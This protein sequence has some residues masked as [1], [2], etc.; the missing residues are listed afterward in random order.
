MTKQ[1]RTR[2]VC[3]FFLAMLPVTKIFLLP[4]LLAENARQDMWISAL[5]NLFLDLFTLW[6]V[7]RA[8]KNCSTDFFGVLENNFGKIGSKFVLFIYVIF[9]MLKAILP[10]NEQKD[11]VESTLYITMPSLFTF[12]PFFLVTF[13]LCLKKLNAIGRVSDVLFLGTL[14]GLILI[15]A[16]AIP[17]ADLQ[18]FLPLGVTGAKSVLT[19]SYKGLNWFGDC[20][21]FLFFIGNFT[22]EKNAE[23]NILLSYLASCLLSVLFLFLFYATFS[24]IAFRQRFALTEIAKYTTIIN[25]IGRFDYIGIFLLLFSYIFSASLPI[26]FANLVMQKIFPMEKKWIYPLILCSIII[27]ILIFFGEYFA[28]I[29]KFIITYG[30]ILFL[31]CGNIFPLVSIFFRK[32]K[33]IEVKEC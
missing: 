7:A 11:Y 10:I 2:Q 23:R 16:L 1:L 12:L 33:K 3:L 32:E 19:A 31:I 4:S 25:N 27:F 28:S 29:E 24:S 9:F 21:Y 13:Y 22:K 20:V 6:A 30:G 26:Y 5:V 14:I 18:S 8:Y 15:L 17:N